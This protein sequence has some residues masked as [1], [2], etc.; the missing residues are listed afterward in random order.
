M[1]IGYARVSTQDQN[2]DMQIDALTQ[3]GCK[4]IFQEKA[5]GSKS[6]RPELKNLMEHLREG[7][8]LVIWKLD[9]LGRSLRHLIDTVARLKDMG[10]ELIS[11][12]N[13]VGTSTATGKL[14]F[15]IFGALAEF[16]RDMIK[17]CTSAGLTS[18]R[19]RGRVG[20]RKKALDAK[21]V[22]LLNSLSKDKAL[23]IG[24]ICKQFGIS[25]GTYYNY[26]RDSSASEKIKL[27]TRHKPNICC[28]L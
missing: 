2:L 15:A 25:K 9:R 28:D 26:T 3:A 24:E 21:Q 13:N 7:D 23:T 10:V 20:G 1:K 5:S 4:K 27:L 11:L 17:G 12:Q 18:A 6:D 14:T 8:S 22:Q 16:E 19:A